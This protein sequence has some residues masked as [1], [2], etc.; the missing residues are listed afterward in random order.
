M[1]HY[2]K[3]VYQITMYSKINSTKRFLSHLGGTD[4][5][6]FPYLFSYYTEILY[7]YNIIFIL[8]NK[9]FISIVNIEIIAS[10]L[11]VPTCNTLYLLY[12]Y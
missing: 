11:L 7:I 3:E 10:Y 12:Y 9:A 8:H 5:R 2:M 4:R 1:N 6:L